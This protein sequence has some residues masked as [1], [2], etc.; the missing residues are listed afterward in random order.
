MPPKLTKK[1][2]S[3]LRQIPRIH[4]PGSRSRSSRS[5][6][7]RNIKNTP[8][9]TT[10][11]PYYGSKTIYSNVP[12]QPPPLQRNNGQ[13]ENSH[14]FSNV[15]NPLL[16]DHQEIPHS[17]SNVPPLP[18]PLQRNIGQHYNV[19]SFSNVPPLPP[20]LK[21][22][23]G[24]HYNPL[25]IG[26]QEIPHSF[27][28][29]SPLKRGIRQEISHHSF[30]NQPTLHNIGSIKPSALIHPRPLIPQSLQKSISH[31]QSNQGQ[32]GSCFA[33]MISRLM[34]KNLIEQ[35]VDLR[36][37]LNTSKYI[38][39]DCNKYLKTDKDV[40]FSDIDKCGEK[41][42]DKILFFLYNYFTIAY[43][44]GC[45]GASAIHV[46]I[47]HSYYFLNGT[48]YTNEQTNLVKK[49]GQPNFD[50]I[51]KK[52]MGVKEQIK[53]YGIRY[54]HYVITTANTDYETITNLIG[55]YNS[56][57]NILD[58]GL[59][60]GITLQEVKNPKSKLK[61]MKLTTAKF[62]IP[63]EFDYHAVTIVGYNDK[64]FIIKN[65]WGKK[66]LIISYKNF[67]GY[68]NYGTSFLLKSIIIFV[69]IIKEQKPFN[70]NIIKN[71]DIEDFLEWTKTYKDKL[72]QF[73]KDLKQDK[74]EVMAKY[75]TESWYK[76]LGKRLF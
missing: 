54:N 59:Y 25:I 44:H 46:L 64:G 7:S 73:K 6:G 43:N 56:I 14:S 31:T 23:I 1:N 2:K 57:K 9:T 74:P 11:N 66:E 4:S 3:P 10:H 53:K 75:I 45:D 35:F 18:P 60:V 38:I 71:E 62:N 17:F 8:R 72:N 42:K 34:V 29:V 69:P 65:S 51:H 52:V 55:L 49:I 33:H 40:N 28:N 68:N 16:V 32:E 21:R 61:T 13:R 47:S 41:G 50:Y 19:N 5:R 12:P 36:L 26:H 15:Y 20:P 39:G 27:S 22:S 37:E 67:I 63:L 58:S 24:Q 76:R 48:L 30:H 70:K